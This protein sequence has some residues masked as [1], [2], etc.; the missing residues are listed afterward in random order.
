MLNPFRH[1]PPTCPEC[2][3]P[4]R[5]LYGNCSYCS[6]QIHI[7]L[8]YFRWI[9]ALVV[10][11]LVAAGIPTYTEQHAG[12]WFLSLACTSLP[13]RII[14]G[15]L[16]PPWFERGPVKLRLPFVGWYLTH[17][18]FLFTYWTFLG[19]SHFALGA[20]HRDIA[21]LNAILSSP[22]GWINP[23]FFI[24]PSRS[25]ADVC[26]ILLGNSFFFAVATWFLYRGAR[27][28]MRRNRVTRI[29]LS[30]QVGDSNEDD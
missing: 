3:S 13:L 28:I 30:E 8:A 2:R 24:V 9:W 6:T 12:T 11:V 14:A 1:R 25:F 17:F 16:I 20:S 27:F 18:V 15:Y 7:P 21:E 23:A 22:I 29:N 26:G 5:M 10:T 19:W 4:A